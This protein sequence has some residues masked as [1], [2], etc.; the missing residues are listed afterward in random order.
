LINSNSK[1]TIIVEGHC[2]ERGS[3]LYNKKL[4]KKRA[5]MVKKLQEQQN[6]NA[7][8]MLQRPGSAPLQLSSNDVIKIMQD[9]Q[10]HI[11]ELTKRI[12]ELEK[13]VVQLQLE[14]V[15]KNKT[16]KLPTN[17]VFQMK[18]VIKHE[19][20]VS[21]EVIEINNTKCIPKIMVEAD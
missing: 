15:E 1:I 11:T 4:G 2:D 9:Q 10:N 19:D 5:E 21:M 3:S 20:N 7:P 14:L 6:V 13:M 8:I 17:Q 18:P 16:I 12:Q